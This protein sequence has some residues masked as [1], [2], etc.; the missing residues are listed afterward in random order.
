M[1]SSMPKSLCWPL[2]AV[3]GLTVSAWPAVCR[4]D[5][6]FPPPSNLTTTEG[7]LRGV[8]VTL[9]VELA[10]VAGYCRWRKLPMGRCLFAGILGNALTLPMVW[11]CSV[12][13][14]FFL[15]FI[16]AVVFVVVELLAGLVESVFYKLLGRIEWRAALTLG[17]TVNVVTAGLGLVDQA[18]HFQTRES[19]R[20][21]KAA[22][23]GSLPL[24]PAS[25]ES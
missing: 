11:F 15:A 16:G 9:A 1:R 21:P 22:S 6:G 13:G 14:W 3:C 20:P 2:P 7:I 5:F 10:L 18:V 23:T 8:I 24:P 25:P 12:M 4:A 19:L 17:L